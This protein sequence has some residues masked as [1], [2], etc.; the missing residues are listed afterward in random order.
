MMIEKCREGTGNPDEIMCFVIG[1]RSF[2]SR[3]AAVHRA[4]LTA[5]NEKYSVKSGVKSREGGR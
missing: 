1:Q 4:G 3:S 2:P 5:F